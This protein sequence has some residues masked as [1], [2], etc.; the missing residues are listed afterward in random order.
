MTRAR[1][2]PLPLLLLLFLPAPALAAYTPGNNARSLTHDGE[3]RVYNVYAPP[4]YDGLE[5]VPL[6]VDLHGLSS[7][8]EQEQGLSGWDAKADQRGFLVAYPDGLD[9]SWNA[10]VCC[11]MSAA[12][13]VDDVGFIRAMVTAIAAEGNADADRI[14]ATGLSNGGAMTHRLACE[15]ADVFAAAAPLA[16][17]TPYADFASECT[18]SREIPLLLFMG[19]TDV[20]VP[21]ENG[22]FGGAVESFEAWRAKTGCGGAAPE[23][24]VEIGGSYCD[25]DTSCAGGTQVGLCSIRGTAFPPPLDIFS[26][27][28]LYINDDQ[29]EIPNLIWKFFGQG[30]LGPGP[31]PALRPGAWLLLAAGLAGAGAVALRRRRSR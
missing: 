17:P 8:K 6:V 11:G 3:L 27:H 9:N 21:Y 1:F 10:G 31:V 5:A 28:I 4:S 15:A 14:Y 19:L 7:N 30:S 2:V 22:A 25:V 18:P 23:E 20:L 26:G 16:F 29:I 24:H 12:N 13:D